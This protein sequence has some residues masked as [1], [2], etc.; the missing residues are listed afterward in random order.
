MDDLLDLPVGR[1]VNWCAVDE[2]TLTDAPAY[3]NTAVWLKDTNE[4]DLP[5]RVA[6]LRD[7]WLEG[8]RH[9]RQPLPSPRPAAPPRR[10]RPQPTPARA[11]AAV[12][13]DTGDMLHLIAED[14]GWSSAEISW[15]RT[16]RTKAARFGMFAVA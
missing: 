4:F 3:P 1:I 6:A 16:M 12:A 10:P 15:I 5:P 11:A 8:R 9:P 14:W 7:C 2:I 13:R